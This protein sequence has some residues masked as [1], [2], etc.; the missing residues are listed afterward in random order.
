MNWNTCLFGKWLDSI[1][2]AQ[3]YVDPICMWIWRDV[4]L[5]IIGF[6]YILSPSI[7]KSSKIS[8]PTPL[9]LAMC[10]AIWQDTSPN[11]LGIRYMLTLIVY[12]YD[13]MSSKTS[14]DSTTRWVQVPIGLV[15][16]QF[17][18]PQAQLRVEPVCLRV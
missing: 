16:C 13:K 17:E 2:W 8:Y 10:I 1:S 3:L 6:S 9:G 5:N 15:R 4:K 11:K 14:L 18:C 7:Y 12:N